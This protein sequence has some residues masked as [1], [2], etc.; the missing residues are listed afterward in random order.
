MQRVQVV[1]ALP[2]LAVGQM[3]VVV[4][5][6]PP[7]EVAEVAGMALHAEVVLLLYEAYYCCYLPLLA[8]SG[9]S[10]C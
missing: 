4:V 9:D 1:L 10:H 2:L 3:P 5:V 6:V 7:E 8:A